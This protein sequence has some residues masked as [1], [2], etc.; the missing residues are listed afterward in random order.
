MLYRVCSSACAVASF[1]LVAC[2]SGDNEEGVSGTGG[3]VAT[4]GA[5]TGGVVATGGAG[6][7]GAGTGGAGTGGAMA[8]GGAGTGGATG[9]AGTGGAEGTGGDVGTGGA[10]STNSAGCGMQANES[11][12]SWVG[13]SVNVGGGSRDYD[14][15]LPTGYDS[16]KA[17]P[18]IMLL[19][20]CGSYKNN[21][22]MEGVAGNDA[23]LLRGEGSRNDGCWMDGADTAD[24][25]YIDAMLEDINTRF[26]ADT[27]RVFAV[28]Y[29]SGSWV[30]NQLSCVRTDVFRGLASVTG[31]EPPIGQCSG[32]PTARIF[33]HDANDNTNQIAWSREARDRMLDANECD[34][35]PMTTP[36]DPN[37]CVSYDGCDEDNPLVWCQTTGQGHN[38]QDNFAPGVFWNFFKSLDETAP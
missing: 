12:G 18:V 2:S 17:Y 1:F 30:V 23:I 11:K 32:D 29:S 38:R 21:V 37:P 10:P 35:P 14:V 7:G 8:T 3:A 36:Y 27:S 19:H 33:I 31:G 16:S 24:M 9:G 34:A 15:H 13:T 22:P 5:G 4:G 20:G 26:C 25:E 28:G 6:T